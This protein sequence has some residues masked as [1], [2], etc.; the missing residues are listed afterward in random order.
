MDAK[1]AGDDPVKLRLYQLPQAVG[2][3]GYLEGKGGVEA[4]VT[5]DGIC[6]PNKHGIETPLVGGVRSPSRRR[7][8]LGGPG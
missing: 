3:L 1:L 4:W 6:V 7:A 8:A 5:L 2:W